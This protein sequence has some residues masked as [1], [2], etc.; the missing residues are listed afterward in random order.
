ML[1]NLLWIAVALMLISILIPKNAR[2]GKL[3]GGI[4]W[5]FFGFHWLNQPVYYI[6]INDY[7]NA[8]L[9]VFIALFCLFLAYIMVFQEFKNS[10]ELNPDLKIDV[11]HM[12]TAATAIGSLMY[13]PFATV[14]SM[15]MWLVSIVTTHTVWMLN[16][17]GYPA[18]LTAWDVITLNEYS[19]RIILACTAIESIALF[20]GLILAVKA[21]VKRLITAF[22]VSIPVIYGLNIVRNTFVTV[23]F[24]GQWFGPN[25]FEIA[26]HFIAKAGSI[27]ALLVIAYLV[28]RILPELIDLIDGLRIIGT[29]HVQ[30]IFNK[31]SRK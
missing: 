19:V 9:T 22:M 3:L 21:P 5:T 7:F 4:G 30:V 14:Q 28:L 2:T 12:A 11:T 25:S 16:V 24:A 29:D 8:V 1:D 6:S 18:L 13:F 20:T 26:H 15:E 31:I 23:A 27:V 17:L 10:I